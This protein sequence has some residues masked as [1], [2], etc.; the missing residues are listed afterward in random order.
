MDNNAVHGKITKLFIADAHLLVNKMQQPRRANQQKL[1]ILEERWFLPLQFM[2]DKL[3]YPG[4]YKHDSQNNR[5]VLPAEI[6]K[7]R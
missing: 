3:P 7:Q 4:H 1:Y 6:N 2:S 5:I